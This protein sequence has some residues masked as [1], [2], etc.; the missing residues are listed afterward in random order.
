MADYLDVEISKRSL[1]E[2]APRMKIL[3][4]HMPDYVSEL[5]TWQAKAREYG[6]KYVKPKALEIDQRCAQDPKYFDWELVKQST[7]YK[8]LS[9]LVPKALGGGGQMST[10]FAIVMERS[11]AR[12]V[13]AL[14]TSS[15]RTGSAS[16]GFFWGSTYTITTERL[17]SLPKGTNAVSR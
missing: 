13:P 12:H 3:A 1:G 6:D 2:M 15:G 5:E 17:Q 7:P 10:A 9:M 11:C 4:E 16:P 8:F 14:P